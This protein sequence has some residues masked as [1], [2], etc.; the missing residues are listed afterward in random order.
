MVFSESS[1]FVEMRGWSHVGVRE[2]GC[3]QWHVNIYVNDFE[4][5]YTVVKEKGVQWDNPRIRDYA[6]TWEKAKAR[7]Q[8]RMKVGE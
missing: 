1:D 3:H 2:S 4:R 8:F 5:V 6:D 7:H